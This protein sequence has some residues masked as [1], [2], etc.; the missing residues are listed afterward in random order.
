MG[1]QNNKSGFRAP[2]ISSDVESNR[3]PRR[4]HDVLCEARDR[5]TIGDVFM[6]IP[7]V[8]RLDEKRKKI[9]YSVRRA[10]GFVA[11]TRSSTD[12]RLVVV[13]NKGIIGD[14]LSR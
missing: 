8:Q 1:V 13:I 7:R 12:E 6:G 10:P 9:Y 14:P 2:K 4:S 3:F 5:P 11:P